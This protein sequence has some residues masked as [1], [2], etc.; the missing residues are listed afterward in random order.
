MQKDPFANLILLLIDNDAKACQLIHL[1]E[2]QNGLPT[3]EISTHL[4]V[5]NMMIEEKH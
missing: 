4:A 2:N 5:Q 3:S 1:D